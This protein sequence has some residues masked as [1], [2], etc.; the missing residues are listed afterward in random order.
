M[1][2]GEGGTR[3][4]RCVLASFFGVA[5]VGGACIVVI[6]VHLHVL[7]ENEMQ[8]LLACPM[9]QGEGSTRTYR[10]V[11]ASF[12]GVAGVGGACVVVIA[13]HLHVLAEG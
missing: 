12:F 8:I 5:G 1:K 2:Q 10:C 7:A 9:K 13:V 11:L 6:A 4:Y 3:T